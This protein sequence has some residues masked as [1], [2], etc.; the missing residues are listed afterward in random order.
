MARCRVALIGL[1]RIA[2]TI[3]DEV[4]GTSLL[5]PWSHVTSYQA[6]PEVE[7]VAAADLNVEQ[8]ETFGRRFGVSR[9]Y[10]DYREMLEKERPEIVSVCTNARARP[11]VVTA[12]AAMDVGV[13]A[14]WTEKPIA[15][16]LAEADAM[17]EGC[18][19]AG[20]KLAINNLR[21]WHPWF[22]K[23]RELIDAGEIGRILQVN[24]YQR[25]SLSAT[26]H[27]LDLPR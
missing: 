11:G 17:V 9:L 8:R 5:L 10:G 20:I 21:R 12:I 14:I 25:G 1:G 22:N 24:V 4:E 2:S 23:A 18:R 26:S 7:V 15:I 13:R 16:S 6:V 27:V 19:R 3:D